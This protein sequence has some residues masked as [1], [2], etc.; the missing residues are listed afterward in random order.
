MVLKNIFSR[1]VLIFIPAQ[2]NTHLSLKNL[3]P[4]ANEANLS[5]A[6]EC[7]A[8]NKFPLPPHLYPHH[9]FSCCQVSTTCSIS[10][11]HHSI[12]LFLT[13]A[14][15]LFYNTHTI[16][17]ITPYFYCTLY[18]LQE[19]PATFICSNGGLLCTLSIINYVFPLS[20]YGFL[21]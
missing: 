20:A 8:I 14:Y 15:Y 11:C 5:Q 6:H 3:Q 10:F 17:H 7:L 19:F 4:A 9:I 13:S 21:H 18:Q 12:Y 16:F 2:S 1:S